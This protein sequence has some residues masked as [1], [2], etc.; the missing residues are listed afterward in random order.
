MK[1]LIIGGTGLISTAITRY[2][3]E[4]GADVTL[5]NR[6]QRAERVP[7]GVNSILGDR[8]N[9]SV[10]EAQ[11]TEAGPFDCVIDMICYLPQEAES[12]VRAFSGRVGQ[13]IFCSTVDVYTKPAARYPITEAAERQPATSF[14][15]AFNKAACERL[16]ERAHERGDFPVTVLRPAHTYGEPGH[17]IHTLRSGTYFLDRVR[18]GKPIIVHGDGTSLWVSCYRDDVARAFVAAIGNTSAYGK[19]YHLTG[20]EWLTWNAYHRGVA[21]AMGAPPPRLVHIPTELL[22]KVAPR[23]AEWCVMNVRF[24]NIFDNAAARADLGFQY[25]IPW[26][27]GV[28]RTVTWLQARDQIEDSDAYAF[29]DRIIATWERLGANMARDLVDLEL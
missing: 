22:N 28:R 1:I 20:E 8:K 7:Q 26:V 10:F 16:F 17:I 14:P 15:Y 3:A 4:R 9:H 27:E 19:A 12:A 11:M 6:G 5:Y 18:R 25:T 21:E 29:Y 13:F 2:L 23:L 24:T